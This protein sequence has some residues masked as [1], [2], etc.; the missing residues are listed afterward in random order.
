MKLWD[1]FRV[2]GTLFSKK[3]TFKQ[4]SKGRN[5]TSQAARWEERIQGTG[6]SKC[7]GPEVGCRWT[8]SRNECRKD[9]CGWSEVGWG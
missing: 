4:R 7:K 9:E 6:S 1:N 5:K 2:V 8:Y 3:G